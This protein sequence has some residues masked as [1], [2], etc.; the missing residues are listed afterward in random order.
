MSALIDPGVALYVAAA[1]AVVVWLGI[2]AY[3][4]RID[5]LARS[6]RRQLDQRTPSVPDSDVAPVR[7]ERLSSA[8]RSKE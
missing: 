7:P 2:W 1:V 8:A 4:W 5:G 3:L 6:L